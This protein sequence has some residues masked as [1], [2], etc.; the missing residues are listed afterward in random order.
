MEWPAYYFGFAEHAAK[1]SKDSTQVGAVLVGPE[2]EI[3]LTGYNG[4]PRGV[5]DTK[6][7]RER[8]TKYLF[9][10]HAEANLIAFAAREGIR[11]KLCHV[12]VTHHPCAACARTLIQAGISCVVVGPASF[13]NGSAINAELDAA[14]EMFAEA[15]V[16][17]K[18]WDSEAL[19][20]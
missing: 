1:K 2:G 8:P 14:A 20:G 7:R 17:V 11:T 12:Y 16:I 10:S 13:A 6:M 4:P 3:R 15:G 9:A 18:P 5:N 19:D